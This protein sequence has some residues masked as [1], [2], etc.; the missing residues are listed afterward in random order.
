MNWVHSRSIILTAL[1]IS[2]SVVI[3]ADFSVFVFDTSDAKFPCLTSTIHFVNGGSE[4][5]GEWVQISACATVSVKF[6]SAR[7]ARVNFTVAISGGHNVNKTEQI[8]ELPFRCPIW[9]AKITTT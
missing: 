9:D 6:I 3:T 7:W 1:S 5:F 2:G 8:I 4:I